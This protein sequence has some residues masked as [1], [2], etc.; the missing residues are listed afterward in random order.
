MTVTLPAGQ[1]TVET[2]LCSGEYNGEYNVG[3]GSACTETQR[4][5]SNSGG[6]AKTALI[7]RKQTYYERYRN[8]SWPTGV[9][10]DRVEKEVSFSGNVKTITNYTYSEKNGQV[11]SVKKRI[12]SKSTEEIVKYVVDF[13]EPTSDFAS[14][15]KADN[16]IDAIAGGYSCIKDCSTG[17]I[18]AANA[19]GWKKVDGLY[20]SVSAWSMAP[21][22]A[23]T[24][25]KVEED[26]DY[27]VKNGNASLRRNWNR[28]SY[29]SKYYNGDV[30]ETIEGPNKVKMASFK[31]PQT[32]RLYGTAANCGVDEGLML[33]GEQCGPVNEVAWSGCVLELVLF[34]QQSRLPRKRSIEL[35]LGFRLQI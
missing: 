20:R 17:R 18:I 9:Y 11:V 32:H 10:Q 28:S 35:V 14:A 30:I 19:N 31:N 6:L 25:Q 15:L 7:S 4:G 21:K 26:I 27:I 13:L 2:E 16:R 5:R 3:L 29:N 22:D 23:M 1:G 12:G 8:P 24:Q 33:S 34:R